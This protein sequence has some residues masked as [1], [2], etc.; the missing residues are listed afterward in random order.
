M[1]LV[2][3]FSQ[4]AVLVSCSNHVDNSQSNI[5]TE[6]ISSMKPSDQR[7]FTVSFFAA[8]IIA[9][10][11]CI[12]C[13]CWTKRCLAEYEAESTGHTF[14]RPP[15]TQPHLEGSSETDDEEKG[16]K[17]KKSKVL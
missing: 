14:D 3:T 5:S 2:F 9:I 13:T 10:T 16:P 15:P 17:V 8:I 11:C 7:T 1:F 12:C 6:A 4:A